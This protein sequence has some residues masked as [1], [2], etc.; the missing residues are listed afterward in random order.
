ML[1]SVVGLDSRTGLLQVGE[2]GAQVLCFL[3]VGA[4]AIF[5]FFAFGGPAESVD[6]VLE[7]RPRFL[8]AVG[9]FCPAGDF[10][11][12]AGRLTDLVFLIGPEAGWRACMSS[13]GVVVVVWLRAGAAALS[14]CLWFSAHVAAS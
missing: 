4:A 7:V 1:T 3:F 8:P 9:G 2:G 10:V 14:S 5:R 11:V 13:V 6:G 12:V